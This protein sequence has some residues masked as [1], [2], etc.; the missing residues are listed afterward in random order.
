MMNFPLPKRKAEAISNG[1]FFI[2]LGILFYTN[3]WWPG[4][5]FAI[6]ISY[7]SRL[8]LMGRRFGLVV[9]LICL[10][11]LGLIVMSGKI[12]DLFFPLLFICLGAFLI[13]KESLPSKSPFIKRSSEDENFEE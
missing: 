9:S 1:V 12:P 4:I 3:Q 10:G 11:L 8:Y 6:G 7:A 2:L 13:F 5:L